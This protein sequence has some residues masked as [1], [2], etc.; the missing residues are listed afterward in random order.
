VIDDPRV[1]DALDGV[2]FAEV[3]TKQIVAEA[4]RKL[5]V[6]L[7]ES[8]ASAEETAALLGVTSQRVYQLRKAHAK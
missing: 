5:R 7:L 2:R 4:K 3:V 6:A 1:L 8:D